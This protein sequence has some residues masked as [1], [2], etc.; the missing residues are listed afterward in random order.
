[1]LLLILQDKEQSF[2]CIR[3]KLE[4]MTFKSV[5]PL[6]FFLHRFILVTVFSLK[7]KSLQSDLW[8]VYTYFFS[9]HTFGLWV[10]RILRCNNPN[11]KCSVL[12]SHAINLYHYVLF[13]SSQAPQAFSKRFKL[14]LSSAYCKCDMVNVTVVLLLGSRG[15]DVYWSR[16]PCHPGNG[17]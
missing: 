14:F 5:E 1:M 13:S 10:N 15:C 8:V 17:G 4:L 16:H 2:R 9:T 6:S 11:S 7:T 12:S 3:S